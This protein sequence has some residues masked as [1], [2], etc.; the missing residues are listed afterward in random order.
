[1]E[2]KLCKKCGRPLPEDYKYKICESCAMKYINNL[3]KGMKV[4]LSVAGIVGATVISV[5]TKGKINL[6]KK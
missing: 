5:A 1:M 4:V 6:S 2:N 3:K